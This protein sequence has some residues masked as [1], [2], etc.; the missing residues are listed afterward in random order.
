MASVGEMLWQSLLFVF[1]PVRRAIVGIRDYFDEY[2]HQQ[3]ADKL[4]SEH[5][6][7][8][9]EMFKEHDKDGNG[10]IDHDEFKTLIVDILQF[11]DPEFP[12]TRKLEEE[13][14]AVLRKLVDRNHDNQVTEEELWESLK[15]WVPAI[16]GGK[17]ALVIV[18][19]QNDFITGTLKVANAI[20]AVKK[21]NKLRGD[22]TFDVVAQTRDWHP[23]KHCSFASTHGADLF[24]TKMLKPSKSSGGSTEEEE[25]EQMMWPDHCV[26]GQAGAEFHTDLIKLDTDLVIDK[27]VDI[28]VDS[29]SGF[30]DNCRQ[31][32]TGLQKELKKKEVGEVYVVGVASDYCVGSTALDAAACGFTTYLVEDCSAPVSEESWASMKQKLQEAQVEVIQSHQ[33]PM[34]RRWTS[35]NTLEAAKRLVRRAEQ[36]PHRVNG[37]HT[38]CDVE[39]LPKVKKSDKKVV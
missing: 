19:L 31:G 39:S 7:K 24:T 33:V 30:F 16:G 22:F 14:M 8:I 3:R 26:Q 2:N 23:P 20:E 9:S 6:P 21:T 4:I 12:K 35:E 29:Y 1:S 10:Y 32:E 38:P 36:S 5:R 34:P 15:E 28:N 18:D 25:V 27:G 11:L 13:E 17:R 37:G